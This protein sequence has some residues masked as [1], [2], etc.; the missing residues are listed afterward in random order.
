MAAQISIAAENAA[1]YA[2][3]AA[4]AHSS[5]SSTSRKVRALRKMTV[6]TA[7]AADQMDAEAPLSVIVEERIGRNGVSDGSRRVRTIFRAV[8]R[9]FHPTREFEPLFQTGIA[10]HL[11][12]DRGTQHRFVEPNLNALSR[13]CQRCIEEL[14]SEGRAFLIGE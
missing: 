4:G 6:G 7:S 2:G 11:A 8:L 12:G 3:D 13:S 5:H 10:A 1:T 9:H 14:A